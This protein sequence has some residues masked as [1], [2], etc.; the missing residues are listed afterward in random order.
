ML[1]HLEGL[2]LLKLYW[3]FSFS[4]WVFTEFFAHER[5]AGTQRTSNDSLS[6]ASGFPSL[7]LRAL[8]PSDQ[9]HCRIKANRKRNKR[10]SLERLQFVIQKE[11]LEFTFLP[12]AAPRGRGSLRGR[13]WE[14]ENG[15]TTW[16]SCLVFPGY[17]N[18]SEKEMKRQNPPQKV[19]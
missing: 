12:S 14:R 18:S 8:A 6:L 7:W 1:M 4:F 10:S 5:A 11:E 15:F 9:P 13:T 19:W 17:H 2:I 16:V 3:W